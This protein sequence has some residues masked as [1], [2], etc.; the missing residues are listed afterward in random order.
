[1]FAD[2]F[3]RFWPALAVLTVSWPVA[4]QPASTP[5]TAPAAI[6]PDRLEAARE[7][8]D[9]VIPADRRE[10]MVLGMLEPTMQNMEQALLASPQFAGIIES[11][12]QARQIVIDFLTIERQQSRELLL[13]NLPG[14]VEA[15]ARA[16]AR[17]FSE[18]EMEDIAEFFETRSGQAY[19]DGASTVMADP[20]IAAWQRQMMTE[21][22]T[23]AQTD[24][25]ELM[26]QLAALEGTGSTPQQPRGSV[27]SYLDAMRGGSEPAC[28]SGDADCAQMDEGTP[29]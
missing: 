26:R 21:S 19:L 8:V 13:A 3:V 27:N 23:R 5:D 2:R 16:Y 14:L 11:N 24:I 6:D 29:E 22:M 10:A 20:D 17:R 15:T 9:I 18:R 1:M 12:P 25:A 7:L 28:V 4:A